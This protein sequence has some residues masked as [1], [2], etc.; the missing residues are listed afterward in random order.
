MGVFPSLLCTIRTLLLLLHFT[1][2]WLWPQYLQS[3]LPTC[4]VGWSQ[5][6]LCTELQEL[7]YIE[8]FNMEYGPLI[9]YF[10]EFLLIFLTSSC[11]TELG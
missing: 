6:L 2:G 11:S 1:R 8:L 3:L 4:P 9:L 7:M 5:P 10:P